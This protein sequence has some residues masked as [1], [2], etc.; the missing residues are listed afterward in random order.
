MTCLVLLLLGLQLAV[1]T[2][3]LD[4]EGEEG[5][6][7]SIQE[8]QSSGEIEP[9]H[10]ADEEDVNYRKFIIKEKLHPEQ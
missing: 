2:C 9:D 3:H 1:V 6:G 7:W 5:S 10:Y 8:E 4:M